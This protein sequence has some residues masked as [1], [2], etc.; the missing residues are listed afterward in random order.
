MVEQKKQPKTTVWNPT[1]SVKNGERNCTSVNVNKSNLSDLPTRLAV[2][3]T[4]AT[5]PGGRHAVLHGFDAFEFTVIRV[6]PSEP[7]CAAGLQGIY[8]ENAKNQS[9]Y[10]SLTPCRVFW[11]GNYPPGSSIV[12]AYVPKLIGLFTSCHTYRIGLSSITIKSSFS[13]DSIHLHTVASEAEIR[14]W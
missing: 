13:T 5:R 10:I 8:A 4:C 9:M 6:K 11:R 2:L 14:A 3:G 1:A 12:F 7:A